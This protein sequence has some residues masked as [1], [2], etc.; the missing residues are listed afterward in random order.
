MAGWGD[1]RITFPLIFFS[2]SKLKVVFVGLGT[3]ANLF[4]KES[5]MVFVKISGKAV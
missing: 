4:P 1:G 2:N 3:T 5:F